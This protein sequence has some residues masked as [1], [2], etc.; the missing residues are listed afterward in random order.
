MEFLNSKYFSNKMLDIF[1]TLKCFS[2][3][4]DQLVSTKPSNLCPSKVMT[5]CCHFKLQLISFLYARFISQTRV[6]SELSA[7]CV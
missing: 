5:L 2:T 3:I 6:A 7:V 4:S 1:G